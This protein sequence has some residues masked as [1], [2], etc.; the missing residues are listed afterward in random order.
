MK[1]LF[2]PLCTLLLFLFL[3]TAA[4]VSAD[5][6]LVYQSKDTPPFSAVETQDEDGQWVLGCD[7]G[8]WKAS[9]K[10]FYLFLPPTV[11]RS[12]VTLRYDGQSTAYDDIT[13]RTIQPGET[14][15]ADLSEDTVNL[16]EYS[17]EYE[18]YLSYPVR[19]NYRV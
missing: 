18:V 16:Y 17:E 8:I 10:Q 13:G 6:T 19:V 2:L 5:G 12:A 9:G 4:A 1:K 3:G 14:F 11:E 7:L 15:V